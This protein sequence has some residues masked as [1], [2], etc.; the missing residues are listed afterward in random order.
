MTQFAAKP[1][2][3]VNTTADGDQTTPSITLRSDGGYAVI[4]NSLSGP[5]SGVYVQVFDPAG[6][7]V[8]SE[9]N[10]FMDPVD[11][12]P[13][14]GGFHAGG[15]AGLANGTFVV[16]AS[17]S[18]LDP[19]TGPKSALYSHTMGPIGNG[20]GITHV[21]D[22]TGD[23]EHAVLGGALLATADGGYWAEVKSQGRPVPQ[24]FF[25][26]YLQKFDA[27][28]EPVGTRV[29]IGDLASVVQLANGNL[30]VAWER[31]TSVSAALS[32][33]VF[34]PTGQPITQSDHPFEGYVID[35]GATVA[36]LSDGTGVIV[37]AHTDGSGTQWLLQRVDAQGQ[38]MGSPSAL[39]L[40]PGAGDVQVT[41]LAK[42]GFLLSW[43][44]PASGDA[45]TAPLFA[46]AYDA[47]GQV[48][49]N[50]MQLDAAVHRSDVVAAFQG[51]DPYDILPT[52]DGGFLLVSE[53]AQG[54][55]GVDIDVQK[56]VLLPG[57][58]L[59]LPAEISSEVARFYVSLFGRAP[60][61]EGLQF[62]ASAMSGGWSDA[63]VADA[64]FATAP[65]RAY[66][67]LGMSNAHGAVVLCQCARAPAGCRRLGFLDCTNGCA[68]RHARQCRG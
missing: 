58:V 37:W 2:R 24:I 27:A 42:G 29:E 7:K 12:L 52:A 41:G 62:W 1:S 54:N 63:Q 39:P 51:I 30:L 17:A 16:S 11:P 33:A 3:Q 66:Y 9:Q 34:S 59:G 5:S 50:V 65:A 15:V 22:G 8:Y 6:A 14:W 68:G 47:A 26:T 19:N 23:Y 10:T 4:W 57:P 31:D 43:E 36:A 32:W 21:V 67:P 64:M 13:G 53:D 40:G 38:A 55:T 48:A 25:S 18:W 28:G 49:G 35:S 20:T 44:V 60:D 56:F 45:A 46:Q 61:G